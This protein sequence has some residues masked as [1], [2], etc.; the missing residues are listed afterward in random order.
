MKICMFEKCFF[1]N[2]ES[3]DKQN[4]SFHHV[5]G[6]N[7]HC[8]DQGRRSIKLQVENPSAICCLNKRLKPGYSIAVQTKPL[9]ENGHVPSRCHLKLGFIELDPSDLRSGDPESFN[10]DRKTSTPKRWTLL[11]KFPKENVDGM[12]RIYLT[13]KGEL[14]YNHDS[15]V[16]GTFNCRLK[17]LN[18]GVLIVLD[19]FR[20][21]ATVTESHDEDS[22]ENVDKNYDYVTPDVDFIE[23]MK[24]RLRLS[25]KKREHK[26]EQTNGSSDG[27]LKMVDIN[28]N[29]D[30]IDRV[31]AACKR[32]PRLKRC[33]PDHRKIPSPSNFELC[34]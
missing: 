10:I 6:S 33:A 14:F 11:H 13:H 8:M 2:S 31:I 12:L 19:L 26:P 30:E 22:Y 15:G 23:K 32:S 28:Q 5:T 7:I 1:S 21:E 4:R 29:G 17:D 34:N 3:D 24:E 27:Y 20:T 16:E 25:D 9:V 18:A